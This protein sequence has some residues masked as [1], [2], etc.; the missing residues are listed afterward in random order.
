LDFNDAEY[1]YHD[2]ALAAL[3]LA[4]KVEDTIKKPKELI[5]AAMNLKN[6]DKPVTHDD[7]VR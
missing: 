3:L 4:C 7:K 2:A 6:P 1:S 5:L